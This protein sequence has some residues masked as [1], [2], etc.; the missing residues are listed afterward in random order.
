MIL[1]SNIHFN[2]ARTRSDTSFVK[3]PRQPEIRIRSGAG[4]KKSKVLLREAR[5]PNPRDG[6]A[7]PLRDKISLR[8]HW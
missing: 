8:C 6:V 2:Y 5:A 3:T 4:G 7:C 1:K